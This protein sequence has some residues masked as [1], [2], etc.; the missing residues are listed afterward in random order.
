MNDR[1]KTDVNNAIRF[2]TK[3]FNISHG[4]L[5][6]TENSQDWRSCLEYVSSYGLEYEVFVMAHQNL[7]EESTFNQCSAEIGHQMDEWDLLEDKLCK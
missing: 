4:G 1:I 5:S 7:S 2:F 6:A 3:K